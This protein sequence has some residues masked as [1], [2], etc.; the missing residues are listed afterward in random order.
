MQNSTKHK[1]ICF[2]I[3]LLFIYLFI[4]RLILCHCVILY[5]KSQT[6]KCHS[7][8][9]LI[10]SICLYVQ[11]SKSYRPLTQIYNLKYK[12]TK[13]TS[14]MFW[15]HFIFLRDC[16]FKSWGESRWRSLNRFLEDVRRRTTLHGVYC[17][18][19]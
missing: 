1:P 7:K 17:V 8:I 14:L 9:T 5:S 19:E 3:S 11:Q 15:F 12:I 4:L 13:H 18:L 2:A 6:C 16:R 10:S